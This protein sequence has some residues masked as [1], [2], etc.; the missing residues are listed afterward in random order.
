MAE[1]VCSSCG[2]MEEEM[3]DEEEEEEH[4]ERRR[5]GDISYHDLFLPSL[6]SPRKGFM[7]LPQHRRSPP[8]PLAIEPLEDISYVSHKG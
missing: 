4:M 6:C 2:I 3:E 8:R 1:E 5:W 7:V